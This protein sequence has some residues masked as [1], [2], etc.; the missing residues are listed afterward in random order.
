MLL[1]QREFAA[2]GGKLQ[3]PHEIDFHMSEYPANRGTGQF[4]VS[5]DCDFEPKPDTADDRTSG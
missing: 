1:R 5:P 3:E 2:I 4:E